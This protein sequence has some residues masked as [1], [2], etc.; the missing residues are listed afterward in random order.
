MKNSKTEEN[1][2]NEKGKTKKKKKKKCRNGKEYNP[3]PG[4][5]KGAGNTHLIESA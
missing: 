1:N 2:N 4:P 3:A 5:Q